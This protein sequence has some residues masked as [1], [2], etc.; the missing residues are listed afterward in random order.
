MDFP[1]LQADQHAV[2]TV[3]VCTGI[4]LGLDGHRHIGTGEV[5]RVFESLP[6]AREFALA[7]VAV[8]PS[9]ECAIHA[10]DNQQVEIFK[11]EEYVAGLL[12]AS[13][14]RRKI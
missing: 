8:H 2:I 4:V 14:E 7:E 10:A 11:N 3:E 9:F 13:R 1:K 5:W 12:A 6:A